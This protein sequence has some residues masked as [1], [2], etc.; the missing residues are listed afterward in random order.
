M[1]NIKQ[2]LKYHNCSGY[3]KRYH[4]FAGNYL[5]TFNRSFCEVHSNILLDFEQNENDHFHRY[6]ASNKQYRSCIAFLDCVHQT[7]LP[8]DANFVLNSTLSGQSV[9]DLL[10]YFKIVLRSIEE[11]PRKVDDPKFLQFC[12][13]IR[14]R[15]SDFTDDQLLDL[16]KILTLWPKDY[17][18]VSSEF[19]SICK[20]VDDETVKRMKQ[21]GRD[22]LLLTMD[23]FYRLRVVRY[24]NFVWEN[25]KR[26]CRN[27]DKFVPLYHTSY[28]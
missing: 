20:T 16:L 19:F 2:I 12:E 28:N 25:L 13:L 6:M 24:S 15:V 22:R 4:N 27:P 1:F 21:Y 3:L 26:V 5:I 23:H 9:Q 14:S 18:K 7:T 11:I 8:V 17:R 10:E